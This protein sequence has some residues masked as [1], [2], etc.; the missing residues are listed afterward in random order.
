[1]SFVILDLE[2]NTTYHKET[3]KYINEVVEFGA[4]KIDK[5]LNV[6]DKFC[7]LVK[8]TFA[9]KINSHVKK[10]INLDFSEISG[11][12]RTFPEVLSDFE[13]FLGD[14]TLLTWS[15]TDLHTLLDNCELHYLEDNLPFVKS[16]CDLQKYCEYAL[17]VSSQKQMLGLS[18]CAQILGF[19]EG[20]NQSHRA[21]D[22]AM[23]SLKCLKALYSSAIFNEFVEECNEEFY[24]KLRFK[25]KYI[26]NINNPN[27]DREQLYFD[28]P[29]CAI[30]CIRKSK[31]SKAN[32]SL[33]AFFLCP[34]CKQS[35]KG[36]VQ[37]KIKY[38]GVVISK[39]IISSDS[40]S[41]NENNK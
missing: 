34:E 17:G 12:E 29:D 33:Q 41:A 22:D 26:T 19:V 11:A 35:F 10:L 4:V 28:C 24:K 7:C 37:A 9:K 38:E 8:P 32:N 2:W 6:L 23:L 1:M 15:N 39:R 5:R 14:D 3:D 27:L 25:N 21:L 20:E 18:A 16:F 40:S 31:W 13:A 36:K 30:R